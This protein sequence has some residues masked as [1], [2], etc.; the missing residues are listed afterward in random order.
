LGRSWS[1]E[2]FKW[3]TGECIRYSDR[4][5]W[6]NSIQPKA[7]VDEGPIHLVQ[8]GLADQLQKLGWKVV[9]HGYH[10]FEENNNLD[11][12]PIGKLKNPRTVSRVTKS[13][14]GVVR[15]HAE[16]GILP[17]ILGGD[18]SLVSP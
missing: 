5:I 17:V 3:W 10:Q 9:F 11:D 2:F 7:G 16:A 13:V 12:P 14:A 4:P 8:A 15:S 18:H 1:K 6:L